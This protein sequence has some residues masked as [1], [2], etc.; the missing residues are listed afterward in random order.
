MGTIC[1][2]E[3]EFLRDFIKA[4]DVVI[5][6]GANCGQY[7]YHLSKFVGVGGRVL[8]IEP[9]KDTIKILK[10]VIKSL[11]LNNVEV[12]N[13]ALADKDGELEL[14]TPLDEQKL[15]KIGEAHLHGQTEPANR[16]WQKV[17]CTSLDRVR[18]EFAPL[19]KVKFIKCDV[20]GSELMVLKG[21][22]WLLSKDHPLILCEIEQRHTERYGYA[23]EVLFTFLKRLGYRA[24]IFTCDE[25]VPVQGIRE[26]M[27]NYI[28]IH[29]SLSR[30]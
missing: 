1:E 30:S 27:R 4:G 21:A 20:E 19:E 6:V 8:S 22:R 16:N 18:A 14:V 29:E 15:P 26:C 24:F 17:K 11:K 28:F 7:T 23:P 12:K 5:D 9:A 13:V 3:I 25:L 2:K 10:N